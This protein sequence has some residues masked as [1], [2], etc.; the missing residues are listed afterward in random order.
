MLTLKFLVTAIM[1][2]GILNLLLISYIA[3]RLILQM[4]DKKIEPETDK[5]KSQG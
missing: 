4:Q 3:Y 1:I 5:E 2:L